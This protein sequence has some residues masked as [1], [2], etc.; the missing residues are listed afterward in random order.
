MRI[1]GFQKRII[2][3]FIDQALC[4]ALATGIY[5]VLCYY[6]P[7]FWLI[8]NVLS[9]LWILVLEVLINFVFLSLLTFITDGRS[10]GMLICRYKIVSL[11]N[12][13]LTLRQTLLKYCFG[14]FHIAVIINTIYMLI[15]HTPTTIF[16]N[17]SDTIVVST[18]KSGF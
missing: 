17:L 7:N 8:K 1:V 18:S 14:C 11:I 9:F 10:L 15:K 16:D 3:Y 6:F 4:F 12:S 13:R 5:F 2:A